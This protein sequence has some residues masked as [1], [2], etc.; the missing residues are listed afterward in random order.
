MVGGREGRD[1]DVGDVVGVD[2]RFG[3]ITGG[4]GDDAVEHRSE[5]E[6]LAEVLREPA[7]AEHRCAGVGGTHGVLADDG[8]LLAPA[9]QQHEA[10]GAVV[11]GGVCESPEGVGR[12]GEAEVR[13]VGDICGGH[14]V[15]DGSQVAGSFQSNGGVEER[16]PTRRRRS[17]ARIRSATRPPVLPAPPATRITSSM[18]GAPL[19]L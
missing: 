15:E 8:V 7:G 16:E 2:E 9:R 4:H 14:A 13:G 3:D 19:L 11:S 17:R 12:A 5:E 18:R 10:L 6:V 1:G